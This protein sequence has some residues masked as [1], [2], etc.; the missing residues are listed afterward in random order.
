MADSHWEQSTYLEELSANT[1]RYEFYAALRWLECWF[2][3]KPRL[4]EGVH[5]NDEP[6]RLEQEPSNIFA[7]SSLYSFKLE[8]DGFWHLR[9]LCFGLFGPNGALPHHLTEYVRERRHSDI[10]DHATLAFFNLFQHRL[11]SLF[12]RAW[13]NKEPTVQRDRPEDDYFNQYIGSVLG[14]GIC[15]LQNR[16][17]MLDDHKRYFA[18]YLGDNRKHISGLKAILE[19]ILKVPCQVQEFIGEWLTLPEKI[20]S[21]LGLF[22]NGVLGIDAVLGSHSWQCQYKFRLIL[23]PMTLD[24]YESLL[25]KQSG[26]MQLKTL[27]LTI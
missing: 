7:P 15:E 11:I 17:C 22:N 16:D 14:I 10:N 21:R 2:H 20:R 25:P 18:A 27:V 1:A 4:G 19:N 8:D 9:L 3:E 26:F 5:P 24:D 12:Y 13:A 6:I 23:G